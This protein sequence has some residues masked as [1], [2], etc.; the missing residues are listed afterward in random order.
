MKYV[1]PELV[2]LGSAEAVVL[3]VP[4]G[5]LDSVSPDTER[6]NDDVALGL[7]D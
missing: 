5:K 7:D 6:P 1:T 3:G 2:V 4:G